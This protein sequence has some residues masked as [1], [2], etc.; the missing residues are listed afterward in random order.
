MNVPKNAIL[1]ALHKMYP[2]RKVS[3]WADLF[4]VSRAKYITIC[5]HKDYL[6]GEGNKVVT[7][8]GVL[9]EVRRVK[10]RELIL[11]CLQTVGLNAVYALIEVLVSLEHNDLA[12]ALAYGVK[13]CI[14]QPK[15]KRTSN[16]SEMR[17][18][19]RPQ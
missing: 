16:L 9:L 6:Y 19:K 1:A 13:R 18:R 3:E 2:K 7:I 12:K 14:K 4:G 11:A 10:D 8:A 17:K 5:A 15:E